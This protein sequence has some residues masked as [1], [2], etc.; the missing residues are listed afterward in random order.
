MGA[1]MHTLDAAAPGIPDPD[2]ACCAASLYRRPPSHSREKPAGAGAGTDG[3]MRFPS[4]PQAQAS[5]HHH[6]AAG[7]QQAAGLTGG[8][9]GP[10]GGP[11]G[12]SQGQHRE[13]ERDREAARN[14]SQVGQPGQ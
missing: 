4:G 2:A 11:M 6:H 5:A 7:P 12:Q 14:A 9:S 13:R 8:P 3:L 10:A 1:C